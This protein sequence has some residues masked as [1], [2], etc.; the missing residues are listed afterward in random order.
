MRP[1]QSLS[2]PSHSSCDEAPDG[3]HCMPPPDAHF[4]TPW[5]QVPSPPVLHV[6]GWPLP[7]SGSAQAKPR[8]KSVFRTSREPAT[9][10]EP[11]TPE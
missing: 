2:M 5:A 6:T 3:T 11:W 9:W 10:N 8:L 4:R 7:S 1:L